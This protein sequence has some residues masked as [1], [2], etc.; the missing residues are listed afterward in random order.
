MHLYRS[1]IVCGE[2]NGDSRTRLDDYNRNM[3]FMKRGIYVSPGARCCRAHLY[4]D[5]LSYE[6]INQIKPYTTEFLS[7]NSNEIQ[8]IFTD[9]RTLLLHQQALDFDNNASLDDD[10][11]YNMTGLRKG[12]ISDKIYFSLLEIS[13]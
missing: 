3:L 2:R 11:Y 7:F 6:A 4:E 13:Y 1:C 8:R 12:T 5:Q 10:A 9:F